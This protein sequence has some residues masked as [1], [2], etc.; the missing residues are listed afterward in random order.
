MTERRFTN[1]DNFIERELHFEV[2]AETV[3]LNP[4]ELPTT[5]VFKV[6]DTPLEDPVVRPR[7]VS[8]SRDV[9]GVLEKAV[10]RSQQQNGFCVIVDLIF[11]SN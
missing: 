3:N 6:N 4:E 10:Y 2:E 7:L 11:E 1:T 5:I 9:N 8:T